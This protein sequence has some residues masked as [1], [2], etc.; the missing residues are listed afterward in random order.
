MTAPVLRRTLTLTAAIGA[1]L[2]LTGCQADLDFIVQGDTVRIQGSYW[3]E[4]DLLPNAENGCSMAQVFFSDFRSA[5]GSPDAGLAP[6]TDPG[7]PYERG[8][9]VD[10]VVPAGQARGLQRLGD[11]YLFSAGGDDLFTSLFT[12]GDKLR[13]TATFPGRVVEASPG[14]VVDGT[15][16]T[17][18][19]PYVAFGI[20]GLRVVAEEKPDDVPLPAQAA[21]LALAGT[22]VGALLGWIVGRVI[23]LRR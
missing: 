7:R 14:L 8:C 15:R 3:K 6:L 5:E 18:T 2:A 20:R 12:G 21:L 11:R 13:L 22:G 9:Q 4:V 17:L 1:G 19:D 23:G 16:V 10:F